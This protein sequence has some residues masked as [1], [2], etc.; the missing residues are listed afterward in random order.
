MKTKH[1]ETKD[2]ASILTQKQPTATILTIVAELWKKKDMEINNYFFSN[3]EV[4]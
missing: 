2:R 4:L 3:K 1:S